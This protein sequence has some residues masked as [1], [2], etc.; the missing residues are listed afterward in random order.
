MRLPYIRAD[1]H[2]QS[3]HVQIHSATKE[4]PS[5][6]LAPRVLIVVILCSACAPAQA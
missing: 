1:K 3:R 6:E 5:K 4:G 2:K